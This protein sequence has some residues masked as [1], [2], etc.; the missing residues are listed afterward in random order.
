[1]RRNP[2]PVIVAVA[3]IVIG[4]VIVA[5]HVHVNPSGECGCDAPY[6]VTTRPCGAM[7]TGNRVGV[8]LV[9]LG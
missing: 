9:S 2:K 6:G 1:M 8:P 5:V 7:Y 3:V 4:P